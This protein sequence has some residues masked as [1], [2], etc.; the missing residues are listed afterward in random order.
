LRR[1]ERLRDP[2]KK[3]RSGTNT[4]VSFGLPRPRLWTPIGV[5]NS[6]FQLELR[7][8]SDFHNQYQ[9]N[10]RAYVRGT[11]F[12]LLR[13]LVAF[14]AALALAPICALAARLTGEPAVGAVTGIAGAVGVL[15]AWILVERAMHHRGGSSPAAAHMPPLPPGFVSPQIVHSSQ[16]PIRRVQDPVPAKSS[17]GGC[18]VAL[19]VVAG[20]MMLTCCGGGVAIFAIGSSI[21]GHANGRV[22]IQ[23]DPFFDLQRRQQRQID[24]LVRRQKDQWREIER[25]RQRIGQGPNW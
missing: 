11:P 4:V 13:L 8:V 22:V 18:I 21:A 2:N 25:D 1:G 6:L 7:Q 5:H 14:A 24:D 17:G 19:L 15:I 9:A 3:G 10:C 20:V 23:E 12:R 16:P